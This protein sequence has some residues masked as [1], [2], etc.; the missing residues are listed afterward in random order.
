M[1]DDNEDVQKLE[2]SKKFSAD[3]AKTGRA[4]CRKCKTKLEAGV[5]R[6]AKYGYNPFGGTFPIKMW[7]HVNCL[8]EVFSGQ[9]PTTARIETPDDIEGWSDLEEEDQK[10]ILKYLPNCE[11][12]RNSL[13]RILLLFGLKLGRATTYSNR[14]LR[15]LVVFHQ[16]L[17][18]NAGRY[19]KI[20]HNRLLPRPYLLPIHYHF[21]I[22]FNTM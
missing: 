21:P 16:Y 4:T 14:G 3:R 13:L 18:A 9:R 17:Q 20:H 5:L 15:F 22:S 2:E 10:E 6:L 12:S 7:H 1:S 19:H 11:G 8:F